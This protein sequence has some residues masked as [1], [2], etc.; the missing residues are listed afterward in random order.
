MVNGVLA[1]SD[2]KIL[3]WSD[4]KKLRLW[5]S[6]GEPITVIYFETAI[7]EVKNLP[8]LLRFFVRDTLGRVHWVDIS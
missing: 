1:F 2:G 4:D 6:S 5:S 7:T 3:S 8:L